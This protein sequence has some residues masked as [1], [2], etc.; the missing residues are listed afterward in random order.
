M[1]RNVFCFNVLA[2]MQHAMHAACSA[3]QNQCARACACQALVAAFGTR[4]RLS[5]APRSA[6]D[7]VEQTCWW[8]DEVH[9]GAVVVVVV[10]AVVL[11]VVV[12]VVACCC[13]SVCQYMRCAYYAGYF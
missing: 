6:T 7:P 12:V 5:Q 13:S 3:V 1:H 10:V 2:L 11:V 9:V 8:I 4:H